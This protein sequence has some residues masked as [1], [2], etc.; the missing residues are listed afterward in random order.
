[1]NNRD[2]RIT[3]LFEL[4]ER[5]L[6]AIRHDITLSVLS[7]MHDENAD[8]ITSSVARLHR[9]AADICPNLEYFICFMPL[10]PSHETL[11]RNGAPFLRAHDTDGESYRSSSVALKQYLYNLAGEEYRCIS[12]DDT[13]LPVFTENRAVCIGAMSEEQLFE[14]VFRLEEGIRAAAY[15]IQMRQK[16]ISSVSEQTSALTEIHRVITHGG[17]YVSQHKHIKY[18]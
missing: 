17:G 14:Y 3:E 13:F 6:I 5:S 11:A 9:Q 1:M 7:D 2:S 8:S 10:S 18:K 15:V 12:F 16:L 4:M